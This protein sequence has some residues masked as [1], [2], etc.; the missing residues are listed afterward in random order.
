MNARLAKPIPLGLVYCGAY[1]A[2]GDTEPDAGRLFAGAEGWVYADSGPRATVIAR[3]SAARWYRKANFLL[4]RTIFPERT[5]PR[6]AF[7][8]LSMIF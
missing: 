1:R 6:G 3:Q 4:R 7:Y 2:F 5:S 8:L